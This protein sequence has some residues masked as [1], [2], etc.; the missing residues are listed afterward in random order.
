M[1]GN[2]ARE[3]TSV[4][5][6]LTVAHLN[7]IQYFE[8]SGRRFD[9]FEQPNDDDLPGEGVAQVRLMQLFD[10]EAIA[11][12]ARAE[13]HAEEGL[14]IADVAAFFQ[15]S[16]KVDLS[17]ELVGAFAKRVASP[18]IRPYL[19]EAIHTTAAKLGMAGVPLLAPLDHAGE[20]I[21]NPESAD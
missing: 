21:L 5:E 2:A 3:I 12:R 16:E 20:E 11:A 18:I 10:G 14:L 17:P 13:V 7:H 4:D 1:T 8:V 9:G 15:I 19:R 6:L